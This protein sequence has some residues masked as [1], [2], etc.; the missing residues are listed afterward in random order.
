MSSAPR[1]PRL[2][3]LLPAGSGRGFVVALDHGFFGVPADLPAIEDLAGVLDVVTAVGPDGVLMSAGQ[4]RLLA[5]IDGRP[6]PALTVRGDV[7]NL[8]LS[9]DRA[10]SDIVDDA[11]LR[12]VRLDAAALL[13]NL[14]D[15]DDDPSV[16]QA[17][18]RNVFAAR[19]PCEHFGLALMVEPIPFERRDGRYYDVADEERLVPLVRQAVEAGAQVIK[20]GILPDRAGDAP[21]DRRLRRRPLPRP[22]RFQG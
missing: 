16:R 7:T 12:A 11:A 1:P 8:Y 3:R 17:C 15:A 13:I 4:A 10:E 22:R 21:G 2:R 19:S 18:L 6:L 20:A 9:P 5:D 14:L